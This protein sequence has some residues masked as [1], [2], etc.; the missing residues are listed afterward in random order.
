MADMEG[1]SPSEGRSKIHKITPRLLYLIDH[2][3]IDGL[4][5]YFT[6]KFHMSF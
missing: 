6:V 3:V 5:Y 1:Q 2:T 4:F